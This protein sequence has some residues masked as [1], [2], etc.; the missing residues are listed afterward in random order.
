MSDPDDQL[1]RDRFASELEK[2]YS[3][4]AAA[5]SGK[6]TALIQRIVAI[7]NSRQRALEWLPRLVV[8]TYTNRAANE[9]QQRTRAE[10]LKAKPSVEVLSA[11]NRAFFGT[12][13]SF[14]VRLLE[15]HG[16]FLGLPPHLDLV[17]DD[18]ELWNDFVQQQEVIGRGLSDEAR[19][20]LLRLIEARRLLP[21]GRRGSVPADFAFSNEPCPKVNIDALLAYQPN[22]VSLDNITRAQEQ[23]RAWDR[24]HGA[25]AEFFPLP[26]RGSTA[27]KW[28]SL[29]DE[30]FGP[31]REWLSGAALCVAAELER[32]YRG[33][34]LTKGT[35]TY[36]DQIALALQLFDNQEAA[37]RI[38]GQ[39]YRIILDEAQDTGPAQFGVLLEASRPPDAAGRWPNELRDPPPPGHFCMVGDF[40]QSIFSQHADL[41]YYRAVH[42]ALVAAPGG[43]TV[44]FSVSFRLDEKSIQFLN[45]TFSKI[46]NEE[47]DQVRYVPM[48]GRPGVLLGQIVRLEFAAHDFPPR[49]PVR[50]KAAWE[51]RELARWVRATGLKKLRAETWRD[52]AI[53]CPRKLWFGPLRDALTQE[54]LEVEVQS[55]TAIKGDNPA[56]AWLTAICTILADPS[57]TYETVGVL[58]EVFGLSDHGLAAFAQRKARRFDFSDPP[59]GD[60]PVAEKLRALSQLRA[61]ISRRPLFSAVQE[62][63]ERVQLR[64]RLRSLPPEDFGNLDDELDALLASAARA[65]AE[66]MQ[67]QDFAR[68]LRDDFPTTR[69]APAAGRASA[70][71]LITSHKAKG[72]E[73]QAVI[74]PFLTREV[75]SRAD[76]FPR[77]TTDRVSKMQR[78]LFDKEEVTD[79]LEAEGKL[80]E[81]QEMERLLYVALTRAKH[82]LVLASAPRLYATSKSPQPSKSQITWL[83]CEEGGC[84]H[85]ALSACTTEA[86]AEAAT[87]TH[88]KSKAGE[89][90]RAAKVP[91]LPVPQAGAREIASHFVQKISPSGLAEAVS[92][93]NAVA[94]DRTERIPSRAGAFDNEATRYGHW[95]HKLLQSLDWHRDPA[96]W[97][98]AF[99]EALLTVTK[100]AQ[101]EQ[102][103]QLFIEHASSAAD[104]RKR[105]RSE[106]FVTHPEFPFL[107]KMGPTAALE[108]VIDLILLAPTARRALIV[109][110]KTNAVTSGRA[111]SLRGKYRSQ[112]T[113]YW[114]TVHEI[115]GFDVEAGL[116]STATGRLIMFEQEELATEWN[117]LAQLPPEELANEITPTEK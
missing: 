14:C 47:G 7:A 95:W 9:M 21:L 55:E 15:T 113:A 97:E 31:F 63:I 13:H 61:D 37:R 5:G 58:R 44:E 87:A 40:Q 2:N 54:G 93:E 100:R 38:R 51:A 19:A 3:V 62:A 84:N 26:L 110:W 116:Y 73:W 46:L 96:Q 91:D 88:Q 72:S 36:G 115:T 80:T 68:H 20:I 67:L 48:H 53:L 104:F 90:S 89:R 111:G 65:E 101:A 86:L 71:Q 10:I 6:T 57:E 28:V 60:D 29:W 108:G 1:Q 94:S 11:F 107:L 34:R 70:I 50:R 39:Q 16:H 85:G 74:V 75:D 99:Q 117:R 109:D 64:A 83:R 82:T 105:L 81:R 17:T 23:L 12:I 92:I 41:P 35:L 8:V 4:V 49:T 18:D 66:G 112:I 114:K 59:E 98:P 77:V 52:V 22:G 27:K 78:I 103:W 45:E 30:A 42:E 76:N 25:N 24:A 106:P 56:Y 33:Y 69:E 43:E 32:D 79:A 102:E